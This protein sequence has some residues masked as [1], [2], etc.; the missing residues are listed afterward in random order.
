LDSNHLE[1]GFGMTAGEQAGAGSGS[2]STAELI[3]RAAAQVSTLVRDEL[4]LARSE[5][6]AKGKR[7]GVGG[8]LF[9][10]ATLMTGYGVG[11][12]LALAV[13]L[14]ALVWPTWLAV[15]VVMVAVFGAAAVAAL[16]G[17]R[18][19]RE[20]APPVPEQAAAGIAADIDA[21]KAAIHEG[22]TS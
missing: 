7:A 9:A 22:R 5:L 19:L 17:R 13:V 11:L 18:Q 1:K 2:A 14:L 15:L 20:V 12:L 8:G 6:I 3:E 4:A 16:V 10:V 21:V